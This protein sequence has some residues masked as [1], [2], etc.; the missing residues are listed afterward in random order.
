MEV[1][2]F[3]YKV[4]NPGGDN[5]V[6]VF[7]SKFHHYNRSLPL[8]QILDLRLLQHL[9]SFQFAGHVFKMVVW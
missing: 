5:I 1:N 6:K 7:I 4:P 3:L 9:E 8:S 2:S